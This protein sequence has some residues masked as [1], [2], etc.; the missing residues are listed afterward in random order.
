MIWQNTVISRDEMRLLC[1][2]AYKDKDIEVSPFAIDMTCPHSLC[3]AQAEI[4]FK[5]GRKVGIKEVVEW[6]INHY[7]NG[8]FMD[9]FKAQV[10]EW[11]IDGK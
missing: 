8:L 4:S 6:I 11:G 9:D 7:D 3:Q 1:V 5:A 10:K 2:K